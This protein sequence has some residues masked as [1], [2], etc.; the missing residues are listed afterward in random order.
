[1]TS[2]WAPSGVSGF[3]S[4]SNHLTAET[5]QVIYS[6]RDVPELVV[7]GFVELSSLDLHL[8]SCTALFTFCA[9]PYR[10]QHCL[11]FAPYPTDLFDPLL[12][13]P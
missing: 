8:K 9:L 6:E 4:T 5:N 3:S 13:R 12:K 2:G 7:D 11:P 10:P 1:M